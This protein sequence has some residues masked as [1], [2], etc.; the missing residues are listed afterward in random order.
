MAEAN[1]ILKE[2]FDIAC[3]ALYEPS[4]HVSDWTAI[5][6]IFSRVIERRLEVT[7]SLKARFDISDDLL[8]R[9]VW[10]DT[11]I[12]LID[13]ERNACMPE[14]ARLEFHSALG[15]LGSFR[16]P[17][18][19]KAEHRYSESSYRFF[20]K[21]AEARD[22]LWRTIRPS[23]HPPVAS[24]QRPWPKGLPIQCLTGSLPIAT[25]PGGGLTPFLSSR[26]TRVVLLD[27]NAALSEIPSDEETRAAIG[28]FVE[29]YN[30]ALNIYIMQKPKGP[31]RELALSQAWKHAIASLTPEGHMSENEAI[32]L[33][34]SRFHGA[35]GT[36][37]LVLPNVEEGE[38]PVLPT[39]SP[40]TETLEWH[41]S[42]EQ[43]FEIK[44][45][46]LPAKAIDC[47][48]AAK[49]GSI[50][51]TQPFQGPRPR[52]L[53][54]LAP[55]VWN[56]S[57]LKGKSAKVLEGLTT[58][59]LLYIDSRENKASRLLAR[60]FP[61]AN[62]IRYPALIL[63][64][65]FLLSDS[66]SN[67]SAVRVL[68]LVIDRAPPS[69]LLD[70]VIGIF[71]TSSQ[72]P[73][74]SRETST[75]SNTAY[76]L[77]ALL[78]KSDRPDIASELILSTILDRPESSSWHRQFLSPTYLCSLS[79]SNARKVF[80]DFA[81]NIEMRLEEP[82]IA[83]SADVEAGKSTVKITTVKYV[84]QLL[85]NARFLSPEDR[86]II[87]SS[88]FQKSTHVDV[89]C[90]VVKSMLLMLAQCANEG[91][92]MSLQQLMKGL[93][94]IIP[95]AGRLHERQGLETKSIDTLEDCEA[96]PNVED[97]K[98]GRPIFGLLLESA[99][100][101]ALSVEVRW[102]I[103]Q[104]VLL[105]AY[106]ASEMLHC[107]WI[108]MFLARRK[109]LHSLEC[110]ASTPVPSM[111]AA[112]LRAIPELLP[113]EIY[114][115]WYRYTSNNLAPDPELSLFNKKL[116]CQLANE[117]ELGDPISPR[118]VNAVKHW[119]E[120]FNQGAKVLDRYRLADLLRRDLASALESNGVTVALLQR[121]VLEQARTVIR[122]F[123]QYHNNW[124]RIIGPLRQGTGHSIY[125]FN[126]W[127]RNCKPVLE[128]I[129]R[130]IESYRKNPQ[131]RNERDKGTSFLPSA[132]ELQL[133]LVP[134]HPRL[135][136]ANKSEDKQYADYAG[137]VS[138]LLV[139]AVSAGKTY[140][141]EL[142]Q[143]Q[144]D[145]LNK[146]ND[147]EKVEVALC[148][149]HF[150]DTPE[151]STVNYLQIELAHWLLQGAEQCIRT[152][153]ELLEKCERMFSQWRQSAVEDLRM[154]GCL[155]LAKGP[156][157]RSWD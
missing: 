49:T 41:P 26:A 62:Q 36:K 138:E 117:D 132:F 122:K 1:K 19:F 35:L 155:G 110:M 144:N 142:Q 137:Q 6:E 57:N 68:K 8:Y 148:L 43:L 101:L 90:A 67:A 4:F 85:Q 64:S 97:E 89:Q 69:L 156:M 96:L 106:R 100:D 87:L 52:T 44:P 40:I 74:E 141:R 66:L 88:L 115:A 55:W 128:H 153:P 127:L 102:D 61:S 107:S 71:E 47:L 46:E 108:K 42:S 5:K 14:Q 34:R 17:L 31:S 65:D 125:E 140:H 105:P 37:S 80:V 84:A 95:V 76:Q 130:Y 118:D 136:A 33:W 21:L 32:T 134:L 11:I 124:A 50:D 58:S 78:T 119:L 129:I 93:E 139:T 111:L 131:W 135:A 45:R 146:L 38:Y 114:E 83:R 92:L 60:P 104:L 126:V 98:T 48:L 9:N 116:E 28:P 82:S 53:S 154:R 20:D 3:S 70:L 121:L 51:G 2:L 23:Q 54:Y 81:R 157:A 147:P 72:L 149:G 123:D 59:A 29:S 39:S 86:L 22:E 151:P 99:S 75:T 56:T 7:E 77:L 30:V 103:A 24:L 18:S 143:I 133:F 73:S 63:D 16:P 25:A 94:M 91:D 12:T 79:P 150:T 145:L 120:I 109:T 10:E 27:A 113:T 152:T 112:M 15:P 13:V